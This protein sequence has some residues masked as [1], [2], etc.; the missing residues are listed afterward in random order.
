MEAVN[1]TISIDV[2]MEDGM[3]RVWQ[4]LDRLG[5]RREDV[6]SHLRVGWGGD[7]ADAYKEWLEEG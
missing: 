3:D 6:I 2:V 5:M 4:S 1:S 7:F